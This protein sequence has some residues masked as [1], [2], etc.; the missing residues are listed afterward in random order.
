MELDKNFKEFLELLQGHNVRYL[1]VGGYSVAF[2][3]YPRYT[4]D[5]DIW[6]KPNKKNAIKTLRAIKDFGFGEIDLTWEDFS[7]ADHVIQLGFEPLRIDLMTSLDGLPSFENAFDKK[8]VLT[9][10]NFEIPYLSIDDLITNKSETKRAKDIDD[11][12][13]LTKILKKGKNI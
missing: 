6:I 11:I 12:E 13:Q 10:E 4:G 3:G 1:I 2:H 8:N 7:L 9:I 5:I